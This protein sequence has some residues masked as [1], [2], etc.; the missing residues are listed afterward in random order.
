[1]HYQ[2]WDTRSANVMA[3]FR[4][5]EEGLATVRRLLSAGWDP[6]HLSLGLDVDEGEDGDDSVLPPVHSGAVLAERA[7]RTNT[8][9][10]DHQA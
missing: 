3:I 2:L 9:S 7:N 4:T 6:E 5:E 8:E 10:S 1:M